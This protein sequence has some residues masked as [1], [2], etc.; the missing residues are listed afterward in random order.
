MAKSSRRRKYAKRAAAG[1]TGLAVVLG[2]AAAG[3]AVAV[4]MYEKNK[5]APAPAGGA[6]PPSGPATTITTT[7]P[8]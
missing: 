4:W 3:T 2:I 7:I 6:L 8:R 1:G 5:A